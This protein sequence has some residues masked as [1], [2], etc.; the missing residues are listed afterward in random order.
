MNETVEFTKFV[1][2]SF[3]SEGNKVVVL[4]EFALKSRATRKIAE[5]KLAMEWDF[6]DGKLKHYQA[7]VDSYSV[8]KALKA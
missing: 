3:F 6:E 7:F 4:G 2:Q 5:S 8:A 1:P